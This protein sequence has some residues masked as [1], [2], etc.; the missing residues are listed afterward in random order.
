MPIISPSL[1]DYVPQELNP[2]YNHFVV[3][4]TFLG[5][6][7]IGT[8]LQEYSEDLTSENAIL[9]LKLRSIS[10]QIWVILIDALKYM[11]MTVHI[12]H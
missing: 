12:L 6:R 10:M 9:R 7:W 5:L 3:T 8:S 1:P 2:S 11:D 4:N